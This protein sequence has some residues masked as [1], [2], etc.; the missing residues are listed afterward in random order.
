MACQRFSF[1][2][3]RTNPDSFT[4]PETNTSRFESVRTSVHDFEGDQTYTEKRG[5]NFSLS[6][7]FADVDP[8]SYDAL[9]IPGG[10]SP[11]YLRL[12]PRVLDHGRDRPGGLIHDR[13]DCF[14]VA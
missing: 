8:S 1:G 9:V 10:R 6:A 5:H 4:C 7:T 13:A 12:D 14:D 11:E 2:P 3:T